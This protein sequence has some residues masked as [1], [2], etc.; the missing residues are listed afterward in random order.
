MSKIDE[1]RDILNYVAEYQELGILNDSEID[2]FADGIDNIYRQ[3]F[4]PDE[5]LLLRDEEKA[6]AVGDE[7]ER[8]KDNPDD[9]MGYSDIICQAQLAKVQPLIEGIKTEIAELN[10]K[11][12]DREAD[13]IQAKREERERIIA[14]IKKNYIPGKDMKV[15]IADIQ[16]HKQKYEKEKG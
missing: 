11:L 12:D 15:L 13:L 1:V 10:K 7:F 6:I 16:A 5:G 3:L 14:H 4:E 9:F 8:T 2:R